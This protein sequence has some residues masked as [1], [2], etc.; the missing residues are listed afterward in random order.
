MS[1]VAMRCRES[2]G[3]KKK[4]LVSDRPWRVTRR[5]RTLVGL[6]TEVDAYVGKW[7]RRL[8]RPLSFLRN[9]GEALALER[10]SPTYSIVERDE[11]DTFAREL[12]SVKQPSSCGPNA[13]EPS[14]NP[15][16]H[17]PPV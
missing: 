14:V 5:Q 11:H 4:A 16:H 13:E 3:G 17:R 6:P 2:E 12:F 10:G 15:E 1:T 7:K 8:V 9:F